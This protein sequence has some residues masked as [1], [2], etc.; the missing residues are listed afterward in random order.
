MIWSSAFSAWWGLV[1][2][3]RTLQFCFQ[4]TVSLFSATR[5]CRLRAL[6]TNNRISVSGFTP[7]RA[8]SA[9]SQDARVT[10][11]CCFSPSTAVWYLLPVS[12]TK[13]RVQML[14][15]SCSVL[16]RAIVWN[17]VVK[18]LSTSSCSSVLIFFASVPFYSVYQ[19]WFWRL[20]LT[21]WSFILCSG[22]RNGFCFITVPFFCPL[23]LR[24]FCVG[25]SFV[26]LASL[27]LVTPRYSLCL[28]I[29]P[30]YAGYD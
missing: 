6:C 9:M 3:N 22:T 29:W 20:L 19:R 28:V 10:H 2:S 8:S 14:A 30:R 5:W 17:P 7:V 26:C 21:K 11:Q 24:L 25:L 12:Q 13:Y 23:W 27:C 16:R 18:C 15:L 1:L 4:G